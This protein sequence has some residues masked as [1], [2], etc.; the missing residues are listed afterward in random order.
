MWWCQVGTG[1][2][3]MA[4]FSLALPVRIKDFA[5]QFFSPVRTGQRQMMQQEGLQPG[6]KANTSWRGSELENLMSHGDNDFS[7]DT[8]CQLWWQVQSGLALVPPPII[9]ES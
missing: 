9:Q 8:A 3:G 5:C 4:V 6:K 2:L 7:L 1:L